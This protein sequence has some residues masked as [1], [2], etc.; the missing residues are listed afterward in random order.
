MPGAVEGQN[1]IAESSRQ[2]NYP[3]DHRVAKN[4]QARDS[5]RHGIPKEGP[6]VLEA[7]R[8][9]SRYEDRSGIRRYAICRACG[10]KL[11]KLAVHLAH[12]HNLTSEGYRDQFPKAPVECSD[13]RKKKGTDRHRWKGKLHYRTWRGARRVDWS[14]ACGVVE[15]KSPGEIAR[16]VKRG[17]NRV[18]VIARELGLRGPQCRYDLGNLVTY[19][20]ASKLQE[21]LGFDGPSFARFCGLPPRGPINAISRPA[22]GSNLVSVDLARSIIEVRDTLI[23]EIYEMGRKQGRRSSPKPTR[24]LRSVVPDFP[25]IAAPL[26]SVLKQSGQFLREVPTRGI[27]HW[28]NWLCESARRETAGG[29]RGP[30]SRF[31]PFAP[32][33]SRF[34]EGKL[35]LLKTRRGGNLWRMS[36]EVLALR[37]GVGSS[38]ARNAEWARPIKPHEVQRWLLTLRAAGIAPSDRPIATAKPSGGRP[39]GRTRQTQKRLPYLA[40]IQRLGRPLEPNAHLVC[41]DAPRSAKKNASVLSSRYSTEIRALAESLTEAEAEQILA[42]PL[43][44]N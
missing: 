17:P 42:S 2:Q 32:E 12:L 21:S 6:Q 44:L 31:L 20:Y 38:V 40:A 5:Y 41:P 9:D 4:R 34:I 7:A 8:Q 43:Q 28:Q 3:L 18:R 19:G 22:L 14:I 23:R 35:P 29:A 10:A 27:E 26:R 37:F 15:G 36:S 24:F 30:F 33:V 11:G 1:Q 16:A 25:R 13:V 39:K